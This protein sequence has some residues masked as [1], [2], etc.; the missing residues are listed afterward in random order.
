MLKKKVIAMDLNGDL[1]Q[2]GKFPFQGHMS[3]LSFAGLTAG[4]R[5]LAKWCFAEVKAYDNPNS[6][7]VDV[8]RP[9]LPG[10]LSGNIRMF[11]LRISP[12]G[13]DYTLITHYPN[14]YK[15]LVL[16]AHPGKE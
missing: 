13:C 3:G 9:R 11:E 16:I 2:Q 15:R 10:R 5:D 14:E 8:Y 7:M 4:D 6:M 12:D 1:V